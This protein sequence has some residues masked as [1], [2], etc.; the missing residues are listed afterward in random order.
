MAWYWY[1]LLRWRMSERTNKSSTTDT[2]AFR[3]ST[4][5][6]RIREKPAC[7][8]MTDQISRR[9]SVITRRF[10]SA[11]FLVPE[12]RETAVKI[13]LPTNPRFGGNN[14]SPNSHF[15]TF[16]VPIIPPTTVNVKRPGISGLASTRVFR[17]GHTHDSF[18]RPAVSRRRQLP[19]RF[20]RNVPPDDHEI[21]RLKFEHV[22]ATAQARRLCAI[23][24]RVKAKAAQKVQ[25]IL[26]RTR[27]GWRVRF[28]S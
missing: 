18:I 28:H 7:F 25:W 26:K 15:Q 2:G 1:E 4:V 12:R 8:K 19:G 14:R 24:V 5:R 22:R 9:L 6:S 23:H 16:V 27:P 13:K 3:K 20:R 11:G 21:T 10:E 17:G